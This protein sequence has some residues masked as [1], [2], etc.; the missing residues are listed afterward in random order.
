MQAI[1]LS[2][3]SAEK[4]KKKTLSS[5]LKSIISIKE[6]KFSLTILSESSPYLFKIVSPSLIVKPNF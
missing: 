5:L 3:E 4:K 2:L 6:Y 1:I